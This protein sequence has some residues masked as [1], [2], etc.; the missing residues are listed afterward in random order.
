[1]DDITE[2]M[3]ERVSEAILEAFDLTAELPLI[4][5]NN[6]GEMRFI[7]V[8]AIKA[9]RGPVSIPEIIKQWRR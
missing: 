1:M 6:P 7:A 3:I 9:T 8:A 2:E 4:R 5:W